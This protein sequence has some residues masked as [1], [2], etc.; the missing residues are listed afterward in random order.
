MSPF[1]MK[2]LGGAGAGKA[3]HSFLH[4]EK[5]YEKAQEQYDKYYNQG[6]GYLQPY[7]QNGQDQYGN[8]NSA[9]NN[10]MNPSGLYDQ[11]L[12]DYEQSD[13]SKFA[14]GRAHDNG[15][16]ALSAMGMLGSTPGL[17]ALQAGESEIGAQDEQRYIDRMI[18]QYLQGAN[19]AQGV[20]GQ[21]FGAASQQGQ[22]AMNM[23]NN[24]AQAAFGRQ[25]APG[26][27]FANVLGNAAGAYMGANGMGGNG[28]WSTGGR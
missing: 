5:G 19:L 25:N 4:P 22:N 15:M 9:I 14:Q 6:Q 18:Q 20:Y 3:A 2:L 13:A 21:G 16:R 26:E 1:L 27:M 12:N 28:G 8:V 23:G 17:Q 11:W 7:N 10:L 24:S